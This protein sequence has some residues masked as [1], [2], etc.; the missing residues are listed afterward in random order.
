M[1][2]SIT[3]AKFI[4]KDRSYWGYV[5]NPF[6]VGTVFTAVA[7]PEKKQRR[8]IPRT[9]DVLERTEYTL[10][11]KDLVE[12]IDSLLTAF[13][14][15]YRKLE[16]VSIIISKDYLVTIKVEAINP[17]NGDIWSEFWHVQKNSHIVYPCGQPQ[18]PIHWRYTYWQKSFRALKGWLLN[19][20]T[21]K[22]SMD[23]TF[24]RTNL[25]KEEMMKVVWSNAS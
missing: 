14:A 2:S 17:A 8:M 22:D 18:S 6:Q 12:N 15:V 11:E 7:Y 3:K 16:R 20:A 10:S 9:R 4:H 23:R 25:I 1:S 19:V 5:N 24:A 21:C 13:R